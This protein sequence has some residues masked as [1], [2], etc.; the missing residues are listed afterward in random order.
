MNY[1]QYFPSGILIFMALVCTS[2][3]SGSLTLSSVLLI[4]FFI[5]LFFYFTL[6]FQSFYLHSK[7][8]QTVSPRELIF[9]ILFLAYA[10][11]FFLAGFVICLFIA[12]VANLFLSLTLNQ[13][14]S[15]PLYLL[16]VFLITVGICYSLFNFIFKYVSK[17]DI[18]EETI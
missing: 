2:F 16:S 5:A 15:Q 9:C 18:K 13:L 11:Y 17:S 6:N 12:R 8:N 4:S 1:S 3:F 14:I 7:S 10:F